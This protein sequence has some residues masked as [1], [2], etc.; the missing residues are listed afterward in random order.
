MD[1][2]GM[3]RRT[4]DFA[5]RIIRF[6]TTLPSTQVGNVITYQLVKAGTSVGANYREAGRA[7]SRADFIHKMKIV[8]KEIGEA[9]YWLELCVE[10]PLGDPKEAASLRAEAG[11]LLAIIAQSNITARSHR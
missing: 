9:E 5:L 1:R 4:K 6:V 10:A 3:E 11:E 8:E 7:E 2:A